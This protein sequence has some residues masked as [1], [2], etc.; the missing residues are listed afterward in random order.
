MSPSIHPTRP[1]LRGVQKKKTPSTICGPVKTRAWSVRSVT[2]LQKERVAI[3]LFYLFST[4]LVASLAQQS[5]KHTKFITRTLYIVCGSYGIYRCIVVRPDPQSS[6]WQPAPLVLIIALD[7]NYVSRAGTMK[8]RDDVSR[9]KSA[10]A[11]TVH[12]RGYFRVRVRMSVD[13]VSTVYRV[14]PPRKNVI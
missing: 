2:R 3:G 7:Y 4:V 14:F 9:C 10:A 8:G 5:I 13:S 12:V 1:P 11:I 6:L